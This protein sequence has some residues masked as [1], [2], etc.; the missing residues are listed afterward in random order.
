MSTATAA[1]VIDPYTAII[2]A[3]VGVVSFMI[4]IYKIR[5][6]EASTAELKKVPLWTA[7]RL[8]MWFLTAPS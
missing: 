4:M 7:F 5:A 3:L 8:R 6:I 1:M 2:I